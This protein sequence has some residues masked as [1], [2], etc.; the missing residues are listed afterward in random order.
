MKVK[1]FILIL[2]LLALAGCKTGKT[3]T[4]ANLTDT[5][6]AY[7]SFNRVSLLTASGSQMGAAGTTSSISTHKDLCIAP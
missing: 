6:E 4:S 3:A 2:S 5:R 7:D 1:N